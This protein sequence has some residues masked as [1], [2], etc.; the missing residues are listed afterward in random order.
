ME[1]KK[2]QESGARP[3]PT[4]CNSEESEQGEDGGP[5]PP[6]LD[7]EHL[8]SPKNVFFHYNHGIPHHVKAAKT[9]S[10]PALSSQAI[11]QT[12]SIS[13]IPKSASTYRPKDSGARE[14]RRGFG[15]HLGFLEVPSIQFSN[16]EVS[17]GTLKHLFRLFFFSHFFQNK[18]VKYFL[19]GYSSVCTCSILVKLLEEMR[20]WYEEKSTGHSDPLDHLDLL[21]SEHYSSVGPPSYSPC[22]PPILGVHPHTLSPLHSPLASPLQTPHPSSSPSSSPSPSP[23]CD[24]PSSSPSSLSPSPCDSPSPSPSSL[25]PSLCPDPPRS[26]SPPSCSLSSSTTHP[27]GRLCGSSLSF[28][29]LCPN[30]S[31]LPDEPQHFSHSGSPPTSRPSPPPQSTPFSLSSPTTTSDPENSN[32]P[33]KPR[34]RKETNSPFALSPPAS[35]STPPN[36]RSSDTPLPKRPFSEL[37]QVSR[38]TIL[39][40]SHNCEIFK[41]NHVCFFKFVVDIGV[42][43]NRLCFHPF[44]TTAAE[45]FPPPSELVAI[46]EW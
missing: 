18:E 44:L 7:K 19:Y 36:A 12:S 38:N 6:I 22:P 1:P 16:G 8:G 10:T 9:S 11:G 2:F 46:P 23:S 20:L 14:T 40:L 13:Q 30:T 31:P 21:P 37:L 32:D 33:P 24:S 5:R 26:P 39:F 3:P 43:V 29:S 34:H 35:F 17:G 28:N 15:A 25:S 42:L 41:E 45:I 4:N 27:S